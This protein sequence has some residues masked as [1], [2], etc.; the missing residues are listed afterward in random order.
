MARALKPPPGLLESPWFTKKGMNDA[1]KAGTLGGGLLGEVR[2]SPMEASAWERAS[3]LSGTQCGRLT[4]PPSPGGR[5]LLGHQVECL[6]GSE[7]ETT[8]LTA[9]PSLHH[10]QKLR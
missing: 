9:T 1:G 7:M 5:S 6:P 8:L 3:Q 10:S 4:F 2:F